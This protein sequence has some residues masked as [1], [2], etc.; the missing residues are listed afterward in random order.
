M[1]ETVLVSAR[2]PQMKKDISI[3]EVASFL[4]ASSLPLDWQGDAANGD[5]DVLLE[6]VKVSQYPFLSSKK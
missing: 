5:Y 4:G 2:V 3:E 6:E 1:A